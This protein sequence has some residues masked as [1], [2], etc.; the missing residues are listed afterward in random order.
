MIDF[1]KILSRGASM[2]WREGLVV[3]GGSFVAATMVSTFLGQVYLG[4][5]DT[6]VVKP[7]TVK[8]RPFEVSPPTPS[9]T[10]P[11]IDKI[12][13]RNLFGTET[14]AESTTKADDQTPKEP[15]QPVKSDLQIKLVGTIYGGDP[16]S[17]IALVENSTK[18][19]INSFMVGEMLLKDVTIA[20]IH[21]EKI[22]IERNGRLEYVEVERVPLARSRRKK[23]TGPQKS[24]TSADTIAPIAT[25]PPPPSFKEEGFERKEKDI[26]MTQA[27]R[28]K[29]LTTDFTKVLQDAKA[30][31]NMRDGELKG[32]VL[33]RIRK[34]SIYEKAG[35]QNDDIVEEINGV[36]L[37]DTAQA[38]RLLQSLRNE[39]DIEVRVNRGGS[40]MKFSLNIR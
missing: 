36:P 21:K 4:K 39:S 9:L 12:V 24:Q 33:T 15:N 14:V 11:A 1:S 8:V 23:N 7:S 19:T 38:I 13:A 20:E 27:Y 17:G 25:E 16:Y 2:P 3:L 18:R 30:T 26:V 10:Q 37:T 22:I 32:F 5:K 29:L 6:K 34:D 28:S 35:L 40:P 31:P